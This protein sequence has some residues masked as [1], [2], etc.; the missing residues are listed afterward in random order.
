MICEMQ[1]ITLDVIVHYNQLNL[2]VR[3]DEAF[4]SVLK[5]EGRRKLWVGLG[6]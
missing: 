3:S 6:G 5:R 1:Q 2:F 4:E